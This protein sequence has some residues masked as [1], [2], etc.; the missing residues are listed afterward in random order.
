MK[1]ELRNNIRSLLLRLRVL[2]SL[3]LL[4]L[5]VAGCD[6]DGDLPP[7]SWNVRITYN[8][9]PYGFRQPL[10]AH[11]RN[12][13]EYLFDARGILLGVDIG[14]KCN[15]D[16]TDYY[17]PAGNY[18]LVAWG[19]LSG[20]TEAPV[21]EVGRSTLSDLRVSVKQAQNGSFADD[22]LYA[23]LPF[24]VNG[25]GRHDLK[26]ALTDAYAMLT[27]N[28]SWVEGKVPDGL[29]GWTMQ[30]VD[31]PGIY[32][33]EPGTELQA[34]ERNTAQF[35]P[36]Q[37]DGGVLYTAHAVR[38]EETISGLFRTF[39]ISPHSHPLF[40]LYA[41]G[42]PVM[43]EIDLERLFRE[44]EINT[45]DER[46]QQYDIHIR[47]DGE[48]VHVMFAVLSGWEE[49]GPIGGWQTPE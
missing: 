8:Y 2:L 37:P 26:V 35:L 36:M 48:T 10:K 14:V 38:D 49:G 20:G 34:F 42:E 31:A 21:C 22:L 28:V 39:R 44:T 24:R 19:N 27:F 43:K 13:H 23:A 15:A 29:E 3:A 30:L 4:P 47:I 1:Q 11:L 6:V 12:L 7:C 25:A 33:F 5:L 45:D 40:R 16:E 17:L 41:H 32:S 9:S 18:T 46:V